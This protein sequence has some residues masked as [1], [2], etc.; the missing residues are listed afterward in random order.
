V[1]DASTLF[2]LNS[3]YEFNIKDQEPIVGKFLG[4]TAFNDDT[5]LSVTDTE[6]K[7]HR[8]KFGAISNWR[9]NEV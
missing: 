9:L 7:L 5:I 3:T 4:A 2:K 8:I 1:S 6:G